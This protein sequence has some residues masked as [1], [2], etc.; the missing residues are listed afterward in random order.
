MTIIQCMVPEIWSA[1]DRIFCHC[2]PFFAVLLPLWIQRIKILEKMNTTPEDII[3]LQLCT[4]ND[5]H[6]MYSS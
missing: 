3:I 2:G 5:S 1:K 4:I 6:M